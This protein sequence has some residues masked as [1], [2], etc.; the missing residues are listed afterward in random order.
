M[1]LRRSIGLGGLIFIG[2]GVD[3]LAVSAW[4]VICFRLGLKDA[5]LPE[6]T[7]EYVEA[8]LEGP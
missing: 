8:S 7:R 1:A 3:M 4:A 5:L 2:I 6:R